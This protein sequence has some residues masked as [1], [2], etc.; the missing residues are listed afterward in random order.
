MKSLFRR[1]RHPYGIA[2]ACALAI[3]LTGCFIDAIVDVNDAG[4]IWSESGTIDCSSTN[5]EQSDCQEEYLGGGEELFFA[6]PDPGHKFL[7][8]SMGHCAGVGSCYVPWSEEDGSG[9]GTGFVE[10]DFAPIN[11]QPQTVSYLYNA[12]GQRVAKT[13]NGVTTLYVYDIYGQLIAELDSNGNTLREYIYFDGQVIAHVES[14]GGN[15]DG[16]HYVL[17][18]HLGRPI[19]VLRDPTDPNN[20]SE[21]LW[22]METEAFGEET[23]T[24]QLAGFSHNKRFPGQYYDQETGLSYNYYRDYDP[25]IGRYIQSDPI[26][27]QGGINLYTY[28]AVNPSNVI[29][30]W[31]LSPEDVKRIQDTINQ[32][33]QD[34]IDGGH[35][36]PGSGAL[37]GILNN[38]ERMLKQDYQI[39][40]CY[41][42]SYIT[43]ENLKE[44]SDLDDDWDFSI[45]HHPGHATGQA[46]SSN[47]DDPVIDY[48]PWRGSIHMQY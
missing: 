34:M 36:R 29:D 16:V 42:Q 28:A 18:D 41:D 10:A 11:P 43:N 45:V 3:I 48:D 37:N 35:R 13:V 47:P 2:A 33:I 17:H 44:L 32:S 5:P 22:A 4:R 8:W 25:S 30:F 6:Q 31:G 40:D 21:T 12:M 46:N 14:S 7:G 15:Y 9:S 19:R 20:P 23:G 27:L 24:F 39:Y 26:G 1:T 38:A